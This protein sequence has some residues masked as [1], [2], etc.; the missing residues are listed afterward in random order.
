[1][2][3]TV[4]N[5]NSALKTLSARSIVVRSAIS[6]FVAVKWM[7]NLLKDLIETAAHYLRIKA[8]SCASFKHM[9][10]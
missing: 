2:G 8:F 7:S 5:L 1:M 6:M 9:V 10:M 4:L 3:A